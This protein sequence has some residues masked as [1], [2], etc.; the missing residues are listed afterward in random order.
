MRGPAPPPP[1]TCSRRSS[2][3]DVF[4]LDLGALADHP[5]G[6]DLGLPASE[7]PRVP[8]V[9]RDADSFFGTSCLTGGLKSLLED[10][11][12]RLAGSRGNRV[13]KL[14]GKDR[15]AATAIVSLHFAALTRSQ[16]LSLTRR[17]QGKPFKPYRKHFKPW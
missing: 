11:P 14:L 13:L 16:A 6:R 3:E 15:V 7:L 8:A 10:V 5:I 2:P 17:N 4:A 12:G 1:P 9:C